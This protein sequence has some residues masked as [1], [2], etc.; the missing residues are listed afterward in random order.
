MHFH[1]LR[2]KF[3]QILC[4]KKDYSRFSQLQ[5]FYMQYHLTLHI[6]FTPSNN[7]E[8][9]GI[10]ILK[11]KMLYT[12]KNGV[13]R[14]STEE[15]GKYQEVFLLRKK[16]CNFS[17]WRNQPFSKNHENKLLCEPVRESVRIK[18]SLLNE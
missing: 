8:T 5:M 3:M 12:D 6:S 1:I 11:S 16:T 4:K 10:I 13:L 7:A 17:L 18:V 2:K 9:T 15:S 14:K